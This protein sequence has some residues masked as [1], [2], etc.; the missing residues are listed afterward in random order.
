MQCYICGVEHKLSSVGDV[1]QQ[2]NYG[3]NRQET[4]SFS[5]PKQRQ[6]HN[7]KQKKDK[8]DKK[9]CTIF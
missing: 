8:D 4:E 1:I 3:I 7:E 5:A 9:C 2:G 6:R